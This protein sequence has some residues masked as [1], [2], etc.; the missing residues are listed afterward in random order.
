L[1]APQ[2]GKK[3][4]KEEAALRS[5]TKGEWLIAEPTAT[6]GREKT[7]RKFILNL[8]YRF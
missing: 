3:I 1:V 4:G 2:R 6:I 7:M 8:S 5:S